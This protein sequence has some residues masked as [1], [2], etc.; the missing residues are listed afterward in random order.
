MGCLSSFSAFDEKVLD[1]ELYPFP[2]LELR[3]LK[4]CGIM[5]DV[6]D[7]TEAYRWLMNIIEQSNQPIEHWKLVEDEFGPIQH[8][9]GH[10]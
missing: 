2:F 6:T 10:V 8:A 7:S 1:C 9:A 5:I 3:N 4:W